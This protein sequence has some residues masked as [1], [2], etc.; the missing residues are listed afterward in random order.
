M[1]KI[2]NCKQKHV[3][4]RQI[5]KRLR[6]VRVETTSDNRHIVGLLVPNAAVDTVLE[7]FFLSPSIRTTFS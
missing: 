6:I 4:V 7:G 1:Q 2:S 3:Q 5:H